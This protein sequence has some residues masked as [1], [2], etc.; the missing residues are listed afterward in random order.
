ML[1]LVQTCLGDSHY[2]DNGLNSSVFA[3]GTIG[4]DQIGTIADGL[5]VAVISDDDIG[6]DHFAAN[7]VE[8]EAITDNAV[9]IAKLADGA[10]NSA[11]LAD[12]VVNIAKLADNAVTAAKLAD[13]AITTAK[14]V[15]D[16]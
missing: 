2:A 16:R 9:T 14:I 7:A 10:I 1:R 8:T 4:P 12:D 6:S 5:L 13:D 3:D 11:K 15:D